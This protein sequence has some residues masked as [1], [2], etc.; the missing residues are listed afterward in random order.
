MTTCAGQNT[1]SA[2]VVKMEPFVVPS[3]HGERQFLPTDV[4]QPIEHSHMNG[5]L[6]H[7][8]SEYDATGLYSAYKFGVDPVWRYSSQNIQ[9]TN[10]LKMKMSVILGVSQMLVG[11][12]LKW[13]NMLHFEKYGEFCAVCIPEL[14][15][16]S[17]TFGYMCFLIF[18][19]W[20]TDYAQGEHGAGVPCW[21]S[22]SGDAS[23]Q[24]HYASDGGCFRTP[25]MIITTLIGMF[26]SVGA[27][28]QDQTN[29]WDK[30]KYY[31]FE[32]QEGVQT[33]FLIIALVCVPWLFCVEPILVYKHHEKE[34]AER[35]AHGG[36]VHMSEDSASD[37]DGEDPE[38]DPFSMGDVI[39]GQAIHAIEFILGAVSNTAS[40]LR[41]WALSL[42]HSQLSEVF[43][44]Y[45]FK[46]YEIE[47]LGGQYPGL[48]SNNVAF[49]IV[50]YA[51]FFAC[52][53][54][55]L[56][57][58]ESLSAFLHAL[59]LQWVEFQNKFYH[60]TGYKFSPL[61]FDDTSLPM[62]M[63]S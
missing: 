30:C 20:T 52:T 6:K 34:V 12:I 48:A 27:V 39:V 1:T 22:C 51:V 53:I 61:D 63:E 26:M 56:M 24:D 47:L 49:I 50:C 16:M 2:I 38:E 60:A 36:N 11:I 29:A 28:G 58:M 25:P 9:F 40:Y 14:L 42:A 4:G 31:L 23:Y 43:W 5:T 44:E 33:F 10:S 37:G 13:F 45:I 15:F 54:A 41:L 19:K 62:D 59:R 35:Q 57:V 32:S 3:G 21:E 18:L 55:V 17:C 8:G 7:G 46:G